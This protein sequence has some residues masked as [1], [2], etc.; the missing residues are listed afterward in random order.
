MA[1]IVI[2]RE[3]I[4]VLDDWYVMGLR[5]SGSNSCR[6]QNIFVPEHRVSMD[7][8]ASKGYYLIDPLK[9]VPLYKSEFVPSLTLSIVG[10]ALGLAQAVMDLYMERLPKAGIGN[11]F[12]TNR[13]KRR[14]HTNKLL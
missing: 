7:R 3:Q 8:L 14:L 5:G 10:S 6:V 11:T 4:E 1:I 2:P 13:R 9:D 12:Y